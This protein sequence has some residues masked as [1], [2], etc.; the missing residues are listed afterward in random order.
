MGTFTNNYSDGGFA[1]ISGT[2]YVNYGPMNLAITPKFSNSKLIFETNF[3]AKLDDGDGNTQFE[4]YDTTNSRSLMTAGIS[5]HY[6]A[7]TN[8]YQNNTIK[9]YGDAGYT[10]AITLQVRVRIAQGGTLNT[11]YADQ[12]RLMT[13][14]EVKQ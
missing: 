4:L 7:N 5:T 3:N 2:S 11:N 10:T 9:M 12:P 14:T 1:D 8:A 6:Q 13:I